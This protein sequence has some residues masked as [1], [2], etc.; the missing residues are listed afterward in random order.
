MSEKRS[1]TARREGDGVVYIVD[2]TDLSFV[3]VVYFIRAHLRVA[4]LGTRLIGV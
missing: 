4:S 2:L 3:F 1:E